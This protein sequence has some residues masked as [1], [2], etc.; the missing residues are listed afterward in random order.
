MHGL[1]EVLLNP[2][3]VF[4]GQTDRA[5]RDADDLLILGQQ[6]FF[7]PLRIFVAA[8]FFLLI[9]GYP[10]FTDHAGLYMLAAVQLIDKQARLIY[11]LK[12][13]VAQQ[14]IQLVFIGR[15]QFFV[16]RAAI[17][18]KILRQQHGVEEVVRMRGG[19][20]AT[21]FGRNRVIRGR[22]DRGGVIRMNQIAGKSLD[23]WHSRRNENAI[24]CGF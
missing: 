6:L 18:R 16:T 13:A 17:R 5:G 4:I 9:L 15:Q 23:F 2:G 21:L 20:P 7:D 10:D 8:Q 11:L 12:R 1:F 14:R 22:D 24:R 3:M 19:K